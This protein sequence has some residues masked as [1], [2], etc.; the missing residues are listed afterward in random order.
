[1]PGNWYTMHV[2][3]MYPLN[4]CCGSHM[5]VHG[6]LA[7]ASTLSSLCSHIKGAQLTLGITWPGSSR[8]VGN[9]LPCIMLSFFNS[10]LAPDNRTYRRQV[11]YGGSGAAKTVNVSCVTKLQPAATTGCIHWPALML[12]S[13]QRLTTGGAAL[14]VNVQRSC[15][16]AQWLCSCGK[17][18]SKLSEALNMRV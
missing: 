12:A 7:Q 10:R 14:N 18:P 6:V 4:S 2:R 9:L 16:A 17:P 11:N 5:L 1:M 8:W 3:V 15:E 13:V